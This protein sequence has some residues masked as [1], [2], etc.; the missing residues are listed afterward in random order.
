[1]LLCE[2]SKKPNQPVRYAIEGT[3]VD[4]KNVS[5]G[6]Q[7]AKRGDQWVLLKGTVLNFQ[8]NKE[9]GL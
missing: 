9:V 1:M 6:V 8:V 3:L 2:N 4:A 7:L 5:F